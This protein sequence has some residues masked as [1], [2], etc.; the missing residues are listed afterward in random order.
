MHKTT[1]QATNDQVAAETLTQVKLLLYADQI[2]NTFG[3]MNR[4]AAQLTQLVDREVKLDKEDELVKELLECT[5]LGLAGGLHFGELGITN[6]VIAMKNALLALAGV[7][8]SSEEG[9]H[10]LLKASDFPRHDW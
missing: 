5:S 8:V 1:T 2:P 10:R 7:Q 6:R 4:L 3:V 9:S